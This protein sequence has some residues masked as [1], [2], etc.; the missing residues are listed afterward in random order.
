[1][2]GELWVESELGEGARFIFT[3]K[4]PRGDKT[5]RSL[6]APGVKWDSV[7]ILAVDDLEETREYFKCLFNNLQIQ[8][9]VAADGFEALR[10]IGENEEYDICFMDWRMPGMYGIELTKAIKERGYDKP[11]VAVM[12]SAY[13]L[14]EIE[15]S[16]TQTGVDK[17]LVKPL[18]SPAVIDCVNDCLAMGNDKEDALSDMSGEF[19][20]RHLL[21]AEDIEINREIVLTL[22]EDTGLEIDCAE[23]GSEALAMVE[24]APDKYALVFMDIHMPQM[25]G[26]EASR[27]IR[28][29]PSRHCGEMPI[30]AMTADVFK[31]DIGK[32]IAAGMN[33]HIGKPLDI[34]EVHEALRKY[35]SAKR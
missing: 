12:I 31:D 32:C 14:A 1:M 4:A 11:R 35:L 19:A 21:L 20:G 9:D 3:I 25:D 6:L 28:A 34:S 16:A 24:A 27:R 33:G 26:F 23:N 18:L 30:I 10:M 13:D 29:L 7:R 5:I 17:Y 2:G 8:C 22:L 15:E